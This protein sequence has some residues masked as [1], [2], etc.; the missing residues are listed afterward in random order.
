[1]DPELTRRDFLK[2]G[3]ALAGA[4]V[5][6]STLPS[7]GSADAARTSGITWPTSQ[8]LPTFPRPTHLDVVDI[9]DLPGD[10]AL[11]LQTLQGITA[12]TQ[13]RIYLLD[14]EGEG[15][16]TWLDTMGVPYTVQSDPWAVVAKYAGEAKGTV[17]YDPNV[18]D[19]VNVATTMA[20]IRGGVVASPE[21]AQK[22]A[23]APYNLP[24]L[25][26]LRGRFTSKLDAYEWQYQ[27][28]WPLATH[29]MLTGISPSQK[30]SLPPGIP[31]YYTT[32]IEETRDI[33]DASNRAVY[34]LDLTPFLGKEAV[35]LR[36]DDSITSDGWGPSVHTVTVQADGTTI[37]QFVPG[38]D[39]EAPFLYDSDHSQMATG[40]DQHRFADGTSYFV[41]R[42][43]PPAGT[44]KLVAQVDMW[45]QYKVSATNTTPPTSDRLELF[46]NFRDYIVANRAMVF[47]LDPNV[48][49]ER[50][51][52]ERIMNDVEP[53]T[54]YLGWFA[55][56]VAGEFSG[57][58]LTSEHSVYVLAADFLHN[59]T[60]FSGVPAR[61]TIPKA[62]PMP[63]LENKIYVTFVMTEGDNV[64]YDQHRLRQIWDD[65][66]RGRVPI[67]WTIDPLLLD[68]GPS[69][70]AYY[71]NTATPNDLLMAGPSGAGYIYP[72]P[73]PDS[74]FGTYTQQSGRYMRREGINTVYVLNRLNGSSVPLSGS[75]AAAYIHDV[76]PLGIMLGFEG[77]TETTILNGTT[78]QS[79]VRGA[80]NAQ[81]AAS[82][83]A[84]ESEGWDG[85]S[86][87]F[88]AIG[89]IAWNATP[90]DVANVAE[91]LGAQYEVVRADHYFEL[92]RRA[93]G[94]SLNP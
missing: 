93:N 19:S 35:Y 59:A 61:Y 71:E 10:L 32:L 33:R 43:A 62:P 94:L 74:T 53:N 42:F 40:G 48:D 3:G 41:Y 6:A 14:D 46:V 50:D 8:A 63:K 81:D 89:V 12:R 22:L 26:D 64:Q 88:L 52:F 4:A 38:T 5:V 34:T 51:L 69:M 76:R 44:T 36:F 70:L 49:L 60:V 75:E 58:Q 57:T 92:I 67:N 9:S 90:T 15:N 11:V 56:D 79:V 1:M 27:N 39:A 82:A 85:T 24:V 86:P 17:V 83:I 47:W 73:W 25:E 7:A 77:Y 78:P 18:W 68:I 66:G 80:G 65:P 28:L 2:L 45:N 91:S 29:R 16:F 84:Q 30:I 20:G 72:T 13:P 23:A 21:M 37:A 31:P 55:Q 54:P 87:L